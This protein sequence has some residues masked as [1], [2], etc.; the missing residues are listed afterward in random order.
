M[1]ELTA[2]LTIYGLY[3]A[4][5]G[6]LFVLLF[7]HELRGRLVR[8]GVLAASLV[9]GLMGYSVLKYVMAREART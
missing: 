8:F 6:L 4:T 9:A 1:A 2:H 7:I 5:L 3:A